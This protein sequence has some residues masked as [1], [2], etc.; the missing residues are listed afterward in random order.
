MQY[1]EVQ[2]IARARTLLLMSSNSIARIAESCGFPTHTY[3]SR[4]FKRHTGMLPQEFRT[5]GYRS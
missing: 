1:L 3:F 4:I 5:T 2:R